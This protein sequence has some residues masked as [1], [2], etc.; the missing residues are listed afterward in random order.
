MILTA[1]DIG[2]AYQPKGET[3]VTGL[4]G[5]TLPVA[6]LTQLSRPTTPFNLGAGLQETVTG[7]NALGALVIGL[8]TNPLATQDPRQALESL[9]NLTGAVNRSLVSIPN[10]TPDP[11]DP[12]DPFYFQITTGF[13]TTVADG[14]TSAI[15]NAVT[16]V[17]MDITIRVRPTR[18]AR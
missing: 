16:N 13:G 9:A 5:V 3:Q 6:S 14:V 11:V 10:G 17:A 1:T 15:Q 12:G 7:L 8:G 2:F 18:A 4:N